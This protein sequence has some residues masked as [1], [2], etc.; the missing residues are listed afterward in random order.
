MHRVG[1]GWGWFSLE[2]LAVNF[3]VYKLIGIHV[4]WHKQKAFRFLMY[5]FLVD[6]CQIIVIE[7]D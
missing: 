7:L 3:V 1:D 5:A 6:L 2:D 4:K